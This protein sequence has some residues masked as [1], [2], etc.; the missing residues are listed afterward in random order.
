MPELILCGQNDKKEK[1]NLKEQDKN[2]PLIPGVADFIPLF[3]D[4]YQ[5][6]VI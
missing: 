2:N 5:V 1:E 3:S 4:C 6:S